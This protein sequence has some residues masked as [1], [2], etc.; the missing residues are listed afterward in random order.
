ML[1]VVSPR[2]VTG[3]GAGRVSPCRSIAGLEPAPGGGLWLEHPQLGKAI[4]CPLSL[5]STQGFSGRAPSCTGSNP[6]RGHLSS[7][8]GSF[9][10]CPVGMEQWG[11]AG[12]GATPQGTTWRPPLWLTP[13]SPVVRHVAGGWEGFSPP[14]ALRHFQEPLLF[15]FRAFESL[16]WA[17]VSLAPA[18]NASPAL[19]NEEFGV[20]RGWKPPRP[21]L[22]KVSV[23]PVSPGCWRSM[24]AR[25][26]FGCRL[27][28]STPCTGGSWLQIWGEKAEK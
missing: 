3:V 15:S 17:R 27:P 23:T 22:C 25:L 1:S 24:G 21:C 4:S 11:R 20:C 13:C 8:I 12:S 10:L 2:G 9:P 18:H 28:S 14:T 7:P 5:L 16:S 6:L 26:R 19:R